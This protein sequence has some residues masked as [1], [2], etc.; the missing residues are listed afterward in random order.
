MMKMSIMNRL[1]KGHGCPMAMVFLLM[2]SFSLVS[3]DKRNIHQVV[4]EMAEAP[5]DTTGFVE[6][7]MHTNPFSTVD[8]DCFADVTYHQTAMDGEHLIVMKAPP[9]VLGNLDVAVEDGDLVLSVDRRYRMPD[10]AVAVV[11]IYAPFV[12]SFTLDGGKCLRLGNMTL[13]SPLELILHGNVGAITA[14]S[15]S[16]HELS[17]SLEGSGSYDLK[18]LVTGDLRSKTN[19]NGNIYITGNCHSASFSVKGNGHVDATGLVSETPIE[20]SVS[21]KGYVVIESAKKK[22]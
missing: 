18:H 4:K 1:R 16:V 12:N 5:V 14:D 17:L 10:K 6:R 13:T 15:M 2:L 21:G 9:K 19:G 3:C 8:I 11:E 20:R 7:S 22:K